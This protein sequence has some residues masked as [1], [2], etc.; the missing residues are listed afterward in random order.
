VQAITIV[1]GLK[2]AK[3]EFFPHKGKHVPHRGSSQSLQRALPGTIRHGLIRRD[4][5]PQNWARGERKIRQ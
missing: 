2:L 4:N 3:E 5:V 1:G